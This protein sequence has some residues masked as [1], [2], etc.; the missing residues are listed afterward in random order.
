MLCC[1][2]LSGKV[3]HFPYILLAFFIFCV[4]TLLIIVS[5]LNA[6]IKLMNKK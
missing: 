1:P 4:L 6:L 3:G 5:K 2:L